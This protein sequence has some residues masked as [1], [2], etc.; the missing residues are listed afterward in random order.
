[1]CDAVSLNTS[2]AQFGEDLRLLRIFGAQS[3]GVCVEV[4]A[5]DG[6][7]G[8]ATWAF[9]QRHWRTILI[10][11]IPELSEQIRRNRTGTLFPAA[12]GPENG[13]IT[14]RRAH[15]DPA[16]SA[17]NPGRWQKNLYE[18]RQESWDELVVPQF[19]LN[20]M[21]AET[22]IEK[23]DFITI[24]V[25]GYELAVLQGFDLDRW[26]PRV[27][28][29]EDNSRGMDRSVSAHLA[30]ANYVCFAHTGVND[31]YAHRTDDAL[32]ST[33]ACLRQ[34]LRKGLCPFLLIAKRIMPGI[35]K[36]VLRGIIKRH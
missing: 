9:E 6:L 17:V 15:G 32:A 14:I 22:G 34:S 3:H 13:T 10:E 31:W 11:P 36:S 4:G 21:L 26:K 29:V 23:L 1:M 27:L 2:H 12:A 30:R 5:Y 33:G 8:S 16:I 25:E 19:T 20:H 35:V 24:D 18:L 28:I 7:T